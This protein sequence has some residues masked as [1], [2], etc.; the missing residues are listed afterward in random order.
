MHHVTVLLNEIIEVIMPKDGGKYFDGTIGGGGHA[1]TI[2]DKS[3]PT[4]MLAGTDLDNDTIERLSSDL[5]Q[6]GNRLHLFNQN[7][8]EIDHVCLML[9]W[10]QLDGIV[11]DLGLSSIQLDNPQ[12]GFAFSKN[13]PLDMRFSTNGELD[14]NQVVNTYPQAELARIIRIYG[15]ERFAQRIA[16]RIVRSR[17]VKNTTEL[18]DLISAAIPR[19]YWPAKIHPATKTFQAIR[20]EVNREIQNL[21]KFLPKAASVLAPDGVMAII[22][23]NSLEDRIVKRFF[24]GTSRIWVFPRGLPE[25]EDRQSP[26]Q[27]VYKKP[28][29]PS[30]EEIARNP[31]ARSARLR[32]A[33]RVQ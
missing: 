12:R 16:G 4:G 1:R 6:Y 14:A 17:P 18:A 26:I 2:L 8:S 13:G 22:S 21:E 15:E 27:P 28:I 23:F 10:D 24:A 7:F 32:A 3:S 31:R 25:P 5:H 20:M 30:Q 19:K 29:Y 9:G 11:L 33:R